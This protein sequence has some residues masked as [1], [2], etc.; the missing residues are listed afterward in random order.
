M[1]TGAGHDGDVGSLRRGPLGE[2]GANPPAGSC[3]EHPTPPEA[4][5]LLVSGIHSAEEYSVVTRG[6]PGPALSGG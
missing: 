4:T 3:H 6:Y 1:I 5:R 2:G